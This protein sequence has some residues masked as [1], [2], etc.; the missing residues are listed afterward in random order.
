[1]YASLPSSYVIEEGIEREGSDVH[2]FGGA[3]DV[4]K[5]RCNGMPV[6]LKSLRVR[7]PQSNSEA[8]RPEMR[9]L[10]QVCPVYIPVVLNLKGGRTRDRSSAV[11]QSFGRDSPIRTSSHSSASTRQVLP[12]R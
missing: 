11:R 10:K 12:L 2:A 7:W 8:V 4:W 5:G 6:A 9:K 3:S 1:M